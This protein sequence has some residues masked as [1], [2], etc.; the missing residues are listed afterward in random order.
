MTTT[1]LQS[2]AAGFSL[3]TP[4]SL[5]LWHWTE[6]AKKKVIMGRIGTTVGFADFSEGA[7]G[8]GLYTSLSAIDLID[9]GNEVVH[10]H[11]QAGSRLLMVYPEFS[12]VGFVEL[13]EMGLK[14]L[15]WHWS[16]PEQGLSYP[17]PETYKTSTLINELLDAGTCDG[18]LFSFGM[19]LA[20]MLRTSNRTWMDPEEDLV[21][22]IKDH[23]LRHP[24]DIPMLAPDKPAQWLRQ[25]SYGT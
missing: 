9:R 20:V 23:I 7:C 1:R 21:M 3:V 18:C 17:A 16:P 25:N 22:L 14:R 11:L 8:R 13:F 15:G 5:S 10:L 2:M 4:D 19:N 12:R 6:P 24:E